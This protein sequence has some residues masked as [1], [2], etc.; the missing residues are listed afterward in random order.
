M[1][2]AFLTLKFQPDIST[3]VHRFQT[4]K[5][6][7][8]HKHA[9]TNEFAFGIERLPGGHYAIGILIYININEFIPASEEKWGIT[10]HLKSFLK[11]HLQII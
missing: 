9:Q 7:I 2:S 4:L 6:D 10:L 5:E 11:N 8:L 1:E 3:L